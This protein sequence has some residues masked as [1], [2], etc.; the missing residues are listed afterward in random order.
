LTQSSSGNST[1]L[2]DSKLNEFAFLTLGETAADPFIGVP[3]V[4]Y[5]V[6]ESPY[7]SYTSMSLLRIFSIFW[8]FFGLFTA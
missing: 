2:I 1:L 3:S 8:K 5:D 4:A 6:T 7:E